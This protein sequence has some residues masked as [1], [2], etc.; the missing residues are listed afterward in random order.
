MFYTIQMKKKLLLLIILIIISCSPK[1][2]LN[3]KGE[4][5]LIGKINDKIEKRFVTKNSMIFLNGEKITNQ[6]L[7]DLNVFDFKDF[8]EINYY[9]KQEAKNNYGDIGKNGVIEIESFK[10]PKLDDKYYA[11]IENQTILNLVDKLIEERKIR[12]NP[13]FVL[14]GKPLIGE[15]ITNRINNLTIE[16]FSVLDFKDAYQIYGIRAIN[17]VILIDPSY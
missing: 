16:K 13:I 12:K 2:I 9:K 1:L 11:S 17:G 6:E 10:D 4:N 8:T 7:K 14:S 15:E 3:D 5:S